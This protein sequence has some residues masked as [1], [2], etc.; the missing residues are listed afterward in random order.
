MNNNDKSTMEKIMILC[1]SKVPKFEPFDSQSLNL[2]SPMEITRPRSPSVGN[3]RCKGCTNPD[4]VG[5]SG[6]FR[7]W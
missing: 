6:W 5:S 7:G 4:Q 3:A 2:K 1:L